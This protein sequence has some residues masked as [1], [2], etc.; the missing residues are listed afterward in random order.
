MLLQKLRYQGGPDRHRV[1]EIVHEVPV[2][3]KGREHTIIGISARFDKGLMHPHR[4]FRTEVAVVFRVDPKH[5][6]ACG[7]AEFAGGG[8]ELVGSTIVVGF[9]VNSASAS[10]C[11]GNDGPNRSR[12]WSP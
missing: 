9:A 10:R 12:G 5:R 6:Y 2:G 11:K 8:N 4:Q 1:G 3:P 7:A